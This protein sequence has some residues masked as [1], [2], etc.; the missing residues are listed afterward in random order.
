MPSARNIEQASGD[1]FTRRDALKL[2]SAGAAGLAMSG[3]WPQG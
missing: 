1:E 2:T 3:L